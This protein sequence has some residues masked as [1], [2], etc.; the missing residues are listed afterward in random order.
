MTSALAMLA[1]LGTLLE[2]AAAPPR[3]PRRDVL[4]VLDFGAVPDDERDDTVAIQAAIDALPGGLLTGSSRARRGGVV[5]LPAGKY[6]I[7]G[8]P[9]RCSGGAQGTPCRDDRACTGGPPAG[10]CAALVSGGRS[11]RL[12]G[13]GP[14]ATEILLVAGNDL[15]GIAI[16]PGDDFS[17]VEDLRLAKLFDR[18]AGTG[19]GVVIRGQRTTVRDVA[20][21]GW[22]AAGILIDGEQGVARANGCRL[23]RVESN[24]NGGDGIHV[25]SHNDGSTHTFT[26]CDAQSN[27]GWGFRIRASKSF[28]VGLEANG[29]RGGGVL[30]AGDHNFVSSYFEIANQPTCVTFDAGAEFNVLWDMSGCTTKPDKLVDRGQGNAVHVDGGWTAVGWVPSDAPGS[31]DAARRGRTYYDD[32]LGRLCFCERHD[33]AYRW[34]PVDGS[35]CRGSATGC[36]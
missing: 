18:R 1:V 26:A 33:G 17:S 16:S 25:W 2:A 29:N 27:G 21:E 20:I 14:Y 24:E 31:C 32:S 10:T 22:G 19:N 5:Y 15:D 35:P 13:A 34:C 12:L 36:D 28:L 7:G 8:V 6:R 3:V 30:I 23:D 11:V 9:G 4:N